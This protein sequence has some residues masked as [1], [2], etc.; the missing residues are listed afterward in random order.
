MRHLNICRLM[1]SS[2]MVIAGSHVSICAQDE[3]DVNVT[4]K[5]DYDQTQFMYPFEGVKIW[6]ESMVPTAQFYMGMDIQ[7]SLPAGKYDMMS[8]F[9]TFEGLPYIVIKE[10]VEIKND[11]TIVMSPDMAVNKVTINNYGPDGELLKLDLG[12]FGETGWI[13]TETG[14]IAESYV[15]TKL[16]F[17]AQ[18]M[19]LISLPFRADC[20]KTE[21]ERTMSQTSFYINDVSER[22]LIAQTRIA[23]NEDIDKWYVSYF[24]TD[25]F[26]DVVL[27]NNPADYQVTHET[28]TYSPASYSQPGYGAGVSLIMLSDGI[29]IP[30]PYLFYRLKN[31]EKTAGTQDLTIYSSVPCQDKNDDK[32]QLLTAAIFHNNELTI[33]SPW[34][35]R[36]IVYPVIGQPFSFING[37]KMYRNL[38]PLE[39]AGLPFS[40]YFK[41]V[42]DNYFGKKLQRIEIPYNPYF[43]YAE[44]EKLGRSGESC[45]IVPMPVADD[46]T[47][48][49]RYGETVNYDLVYVD[50][51]LLQENKEVDGVHDITLVNSD[52]EVDGLSGKNTATIHYDDKADDKTPPTLTMLQF[53]RSDGCITD[54]F[55]TGVDGTMEFSAADFEKIYVPEVFDYI[56]DSKPA[57]IMVE[58]APY[59]KDEWTPLL[60]EECTGGEGIFGWGYVYRASLKDVQGEAEKGWFDVRFTMNDEAGNTHVQTVSP[61][62]RIDNMAATGVESVCSD[63]KK[64]VKRYGMDGRVVDALQKG[65]S[66]VVLQNGDVRKVV[67]K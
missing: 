45:P 34:G 27:S 3:P 54:R 61:A 64:E 29:N 4:I 36:S 55:E 2:L 40:Y 18:K 15:E 39:Q 19:S 44:S 65:I 22:F 47:Y 60:I 17:K 30:G 53:R 57:E 7:T 51:L 56:A 48:I 12:Y 9:Q 59:N 42:Q 24:S 8:Y 14:N 41:I 43:S 25:K 38:G 46:V 63:E 23:R 13:T 20:A 1:A 62:F 66:I 35:Q 31:A 52:V 32:L 67:N 50:S 49:G 21:D 28:W 16:I 58:Y 10:Q 33:D 26:K 6:S 11:T 5:L 37:E